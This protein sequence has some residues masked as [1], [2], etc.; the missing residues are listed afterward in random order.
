[1]LIACRCV[2]AEEI[3]I[4]ITELRAVICYLRLFSEHNH[5]GCFVKDVPCCLCS[6]IGTGQQDSVGIRC[7]SSSVS[8]HLDRG[9]CTCKKRILPDCVHKVL[10]TNLTKRGVV[11][12]EDEPRSLQVLVLPFVE[13][14]S[15]TVSGSLHDFILPRSFLR[16]GTF[17]GIVRRTPMLDTSRILSVAPKFLTNVSSSSYEYP[18][19]KEPVAILQPSPSHVLYFAF[20]TSGHERTMM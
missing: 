8:H 20:S 14:G 12:V 18:R 15:L 6:H 7:S 19:W 1:M 13:S 17:Y 5:M 11:L 3:G 2:L 10:R 16:G 4:Q 9:G